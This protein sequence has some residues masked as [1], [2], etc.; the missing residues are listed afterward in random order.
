[1]IAAGP[2]LAAWFAS[3]YDMPSAPAGDA[4]APERLEYNFAC[5]VAAPGQE[6]TV[7]AAGAYDDGELDWWA[8]DIDTAA[9]DF[10]AE[11]TPRPPEKREVLSFIPVPVSFAGMPSPRFWEME[12]RKTEFADINLAYHRHRQDPA[13][14]NRTDLCQ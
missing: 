8:F 9:G 13:L 11:T 5:T 1:M 2:T 10:G 12:D 4:W 6:Q 14:P 7:L 3:L